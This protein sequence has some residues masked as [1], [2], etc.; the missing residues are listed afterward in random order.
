M[1]EILK[2]RH[3]K[4]FQV[5]TSPEACAFFHDGEK[6][7]KPGQSIIGPDGPG[8]VV[9]AGEMFDLKVLFIALDAEQGESPDEVIITYDFQCLTDVTNLKDRGFSLED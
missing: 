7:A 8:K 3:G 6:R 4:E 9:G 2:D 1:A 5:N